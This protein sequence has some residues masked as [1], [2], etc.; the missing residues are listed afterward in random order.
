MNSRSIP[1]HGFRP[2]QGLIRLGDSYGNQRVDQACRRA[3][4][5]NIVGY[6]HIASMLKT[7]RDKIPLADDEPVYPVI[8]HDNVRGAQYYQ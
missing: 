3:L 1:E 2:C 7:G 8:T 5:L 4:K 6:K